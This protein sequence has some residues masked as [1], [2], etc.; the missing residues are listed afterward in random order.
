MHGR[1][2]VLAL[3]LGLGTVGCAR[4]AP[5]PA[6]AAPPAP[7]S[8]SPSPRPPSLIGAG[9]GIDHVTIMTADLA[10]ARASYAALGFTVTPYGQFPDGFENAVVYFADDTYVELYGVH[11]RALA[12]ASETAY[13]LEQP[14]GA[15]WNILHVDSTERAAA[16]L[17]AARPPVFGPAAYPEPDAWTWKLAGLEQPGPGGRL[18]VI[19]Y[20]EPAIAARRAKDPAKA[21]ARAR[22]ASGATRLR[23][24]W[25]A[26]RDLDATVRAYA[27]LGLPPGRAIASDRLDAIGREIPAG[28][29]SILVVAPRA[30]T[31]PVADLLGDRAEAYLGLSVEVADLAVARA[32][33]PA[34]GPVAD[35]PFGPSVLIA[36]GHSHG[37]WLELY[38]RPR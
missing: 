24:L 10:T 8:P 30:A 21:A 34:A 7:P 14:E 6:P 3:A 4:G 16:Q 29:G 25:V 17:R 36:P 15:L 2:I 27:E 37:V 22:H 9:R 33:A 19:E 23:A 28:R 38:A 1:A 35:G 32:A 5:P 18:F 11:D 20:N 26:T 31:G 12:A 13:A